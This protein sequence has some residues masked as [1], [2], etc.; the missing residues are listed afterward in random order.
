MHAASLSSDAQ[1]MYEYLSKYLYEC[2]S[3]FNLFVC[4]FPTVCLRL[5]VTVCLSF[6]VCFRLYLSVC[7]FSSVFIHL[8]T[9]VCLIPSVFVCLSPS[10]FVSR[11]SS[12]H[13]FRL[14]LAIY[15]PLS[16]TVC[17]IIHLS[18][19]LT[20]HLTEVHAVKEAS[21]KLESL[22]PMFMSSAMAV[23]QNSFDNAAASRLGFL[24]R[25]WISKV[26]LLV[27][28][29]DDVTDL[30]DL[31]KVSG[32]FLFSCSLMSC[33]TIC[34]LF[35]ISSHR[36]Q[37]KRGQLGKKIKYFNRTTHMC[38]YTTFKLLWSTLLVF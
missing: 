24:S 31:L 6:T 16:V 23:K 21:S 36:I 34:H 32:R 2:L 13:C 12:F 1:S 38:I 11:P 30:Q 4:L 3:V 35:S 37:W 19:I 14:S 7:M 17:Y 18:L 28:A 33:F 25:E 20:F 27:D 22:L 8:S 29:L 15:L 9:S 5:F 10:F 26:Q